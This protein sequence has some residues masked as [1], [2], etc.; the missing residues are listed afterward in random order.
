MGG[1]AQYRWQPVEVVDERYAG[2]YQRDGEGWRKGSGAG[3]DGDHHAGQ[4]ADAAD[5]RYRLGVQGAFIWVVERQARRIEAQHEPDHA[6]APE[7][8]DQK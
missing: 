6:G 5:A 2:E 3:S 1:E 4:H 8:R 7:R